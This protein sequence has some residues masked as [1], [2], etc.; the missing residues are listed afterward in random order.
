MFFAFCI[1]PCRSRPA[2][3]IL[4][5][6]AKGS[7]SD[8]KEDAASAQGG[9]ILYVISSFD[10]GQ[11]LGP[12]FKVDKLDFILMM[13]D[14]MREAC[15]VSRT[16]WAMF[17]HFLYELAVF[18]S[19]LVRAVAP[20]ALS[21]RSSTADPMA[22]DFPGIGFRTTGCPTSKTHKIILVRFGTAWALGTVWEEVVYH[23]QT[24][25]CLKR[26]GRFCEF[27]RW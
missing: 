7:V 11:R 17:N 10:R 5:L 27:Y 22:I 24:G 6:C 3:S 14:E 18:C 9:R 15:E 19:G 23:G 8:Q 21:V 25:L 2:S 1:R 13:M 16:R 26:R 4:S 12:F 20:S